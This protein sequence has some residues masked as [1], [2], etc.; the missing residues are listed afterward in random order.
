[1]Q[2]RRLENQVEHRLVVRS[3]DD[4]SATLHLPKSYCHHCGS[5]NI[6]WRDIRP[7][8]SLYSWTVVWHS[9]HEA[10]PAPC[11]VVLVALDDE[12]EV[13]F[14]GYLPGAPELEA[15]MPMRAW[16][17]DVEPGVTIPQWAPVES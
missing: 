11:T 13:R 2:P 14:V 17:E 1:M 7:A 10:F 8:G 5:W 3:C 6:G 4:C 12:P 15:G 16:F 9:I